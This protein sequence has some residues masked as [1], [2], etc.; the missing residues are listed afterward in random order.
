MASLEG[1]T[2]EEVRL[3]L[4][5]VLGADG[6]T[7]DQVDLQHA[8]SEL[9]SERLGEATT[10]DELEAAL[11]LAGDDLTSLLQGL[12]AGYIYQRFCTTMYQGLLSKWGVDRAET[13]LAEIRDYISSNL[14]LEGQSKDLRD[15]DWTGTEGAKLVDGIL[16]DTIKVFGGTEE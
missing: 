10:L 3:A 14:Q 16:D 2:V 13:A 1:K 4:T 12:F 9:I 11:R 5:A 15:V 6:S 7:I 8:L